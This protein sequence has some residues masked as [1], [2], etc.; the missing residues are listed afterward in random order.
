MNRAEFE[1]LRAI[2]EKAIHVDIVF[3]VEKATSPV[4]SFDKVIVENEM[5]LDLIL[6]GHYNPLIPSFTYNFV[7]RGE[8]P[9]CRVD[10]NGTIHGKAGRTHKHELMTENCSRRN[11][12]TAF[13]RSDFANR[14]PREVWEALCAEAHI[15]HAGDFNDPED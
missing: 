6:S 5:G 9:I 1:R 7:V 11:L 12:P 14:N 4:L 3:K 13:A 15:F 8:G 10:V 2:P